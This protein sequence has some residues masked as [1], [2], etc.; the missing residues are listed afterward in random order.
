MSNNVTYRKMVSEDV[1][2]V[3]EIELATFPTPWTLDSFY[4]EVHE[5]QYAHYVLAIDE[6]N[7]IIGFCGMWMVID[8]A[9]ITNVA[10]IEAARGRGIGEG[11]MREVMRIARVHTMEVMSLEVRVTNTVAQNLY[12]KLDFQDGGIRK[13]YYTDNGEDA[14]VMWVNL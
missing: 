4:Y 11:L 1:P 5:N 12:R 7:N 9:Q 14:L 8:A 6:D 10:V 2:A 13:G 3:Y